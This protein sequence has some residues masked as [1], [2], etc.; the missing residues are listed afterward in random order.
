MLSSGVPLFLNRLMPEKDLRGIIWNE[1][2][3]HDWEIIQC[4]H[5]DARKPQLTVESSKYH[6]EQGHLEVIQ[7]F[8]ANGCHWNIWLCTSAARYG[9]LEVLQWARA[10]GCPWDRWTCFY[11]E[12]KGHLKVLE[13]AR[14]NGCPK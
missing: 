12:A 14:A 5:D 9:H 1:L 13:W 4:A 7:W 8:R 10:N 6:A 2:T 3:L 11:A